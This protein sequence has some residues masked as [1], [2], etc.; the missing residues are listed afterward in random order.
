MRREV[1]QNAWYVPYH[2]HHSCDLLVDICNREAGFSYG[3]VGMCLQVE[4]EVVL[5][6]PKPSHHTC[7]IGF[8]LEARSEV[9]H[10][11]CMR[12]G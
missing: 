3:D 9:D 4:P 10:R 8:P 1:P 12:D 11:E 2:R 7:E 6:H 5:V